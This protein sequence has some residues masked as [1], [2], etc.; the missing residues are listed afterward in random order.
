MIEWLGY[1]LNAPN[2][3]EGYNALLNAIRT[4]NSLDSDLREL[5]VS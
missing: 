2:I 3:A 5:L 4:A 1:R